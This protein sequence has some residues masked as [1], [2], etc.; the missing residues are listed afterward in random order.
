MR[1]DRA[2]QWQHAC[3]ARLLQAETCPPPPHHVHNAGLPCSC[4]TGSQR[5]LWLP[6]PWQGPSN[7]TT[8]SGA[9]T[10]GAIAGIV[11]G[12]VVALVLLAALVYFGLIR[13]GYAESGMPC[14]AMRLAG[15]LHCRPEW[16]CWPV[17]LPGQA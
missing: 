6:L 12:S 7:T 11:T 15:S 4:G 17:P 3:C 8:H 5:V 1:H 16:R 10:A 9:L 13:S 2:A 14:H